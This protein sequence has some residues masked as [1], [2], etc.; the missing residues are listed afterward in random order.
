MKIENGSLVVTVQGVEKTVQLP[1]VAADAK[2]KAWAVPADYRADGLFVAVT[3]K[4][5][6]EEIPACDLAACEFLGELELGKMNP[7]FTFEDSLMYYFDKRNKQLYSSR[8]ALSAVHTGLNNATTQTE[9]NS[10]MFLNDI[11][12]LTLVVPEH[13]DYDL[14]TLVPGQV[15]IE[16]NTLTMV[17]QLRT[18]IDVDQ[19]RKSLWT[20]A[21]A[22]LD[23]FYKKYTEGTPAIEQA[24]WGT[25]LMEANFVKSYFDTPDIMP[26]GNTPVLDLMVLRRKVE[27][28]T[29]FDLARLVLA[30]ADRYSVLAADL[31]G[32]WQ[33][34]DR[35]LRAATTLE[36]L[37]QVNITIHDPVVQA[38]QA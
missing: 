15:S 16:N 13:I 11:E 33:A 27:G 12:V 38:N 32:Q 14:Y 21:E 28:E 30:A 7:L 31:V 5:E 36:E 17:A 26:D 25:Q 20:K 6:S 37:I 34:I 23:A 35:A 24:S 9:A 10:Y 3:I 1:T 19:Y 29:V 2:V 8:E 22:E 4:G 18:D